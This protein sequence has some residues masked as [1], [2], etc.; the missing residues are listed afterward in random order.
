[1][2]HRL[3]KIVSFTLFLALQAIC[4]CQTE[5]LVTINPAT[6]VHTRIDSIPGVKFIQLGTS[7]TDKQNSRYIF[8]GQDANGDWRLYTIQMANAGIVFTLFFR[9]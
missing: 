8:K 2:P 6:G 5:Y 9:T 7:T 4:H 1:M 3:M